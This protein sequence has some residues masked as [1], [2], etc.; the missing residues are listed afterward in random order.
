MNETSIEILFYMDSHE[1]Y[2]ATSRADIYNQLVC[3]TQCN[4]HYAQQMKSVI[5]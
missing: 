2:F 5:V 1:M 4:M 3:T